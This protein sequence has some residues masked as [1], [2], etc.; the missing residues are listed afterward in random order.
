MS[1]DNPVVAI[2]RYDKMFCS[3]CLTD[4]VER[5]IWE[6]PELSSRLM[7]QND[8][9]VVHSGD[10]KGREKC[11]VCGSKIRPVLFPGG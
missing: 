4:S 7:Q 3:R 2:K 5:E 6:N 8:I 11:D 9:S 1:T 10:L